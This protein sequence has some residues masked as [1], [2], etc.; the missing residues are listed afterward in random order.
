MA[1]ETS[2]N[3]LIAK[4]NN[5]PTIV[6]EKLTPNARLGKQ[7]GLK[8]V[9]GPDVTGL[10]ITNAE[11]KT[12]KLTLCVGRVQTLPNGSTAKIWLV[13]IPADKVG[14]ETFTIADSGNDVT[15]QEATVEVTI[16]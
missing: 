9:T 8:I 5:S 4:S 3:N 15:G 16:K 10:T 7:I 12:E 6:I 13:Y 2:Q 14:A 11:G 1:L